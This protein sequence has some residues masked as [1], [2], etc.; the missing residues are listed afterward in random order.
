MSQLAL[1]PCPGDKATRNK[2]GLGLREAAR[3]ISEHKFKMSS[4]YLSQIENNENNLRGFGDGALGTGA[5][6]T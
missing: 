3:A 6:G 1:G 4:P 2:M 5:L